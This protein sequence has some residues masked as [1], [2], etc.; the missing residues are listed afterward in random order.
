[1]AAMAM[2]FPDV[3]GAATA[4]ERGGTPSRAPPGLEILPLGCGP[5]FRPPVRSRRSTCRDRETER[6]KVSSRRAAPGAFD[7]LLAVVAASI[8]VARF[9]HVLYLVR[10][11]MSAR[12]F[13]RRE[14]ARFRVAP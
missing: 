4:D 6:R 2:G 8:A 1:M 10:L 12:G 5:K 7:L 11:R 14:A 13:N 9:A 3:P